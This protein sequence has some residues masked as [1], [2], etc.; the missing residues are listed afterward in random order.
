MA[1]LSKP[2]VYPTLGLLEIHDGDTFRLHIDVGFE[3]DAWPWLRLKGAFCPE[4]SAP[5]GKEARDFALN[6]LA[7]AGDQI[8]V[9]T[10]K[11]KGY[12]DMKKSFARY[13]AD[14]WLYGE[15]G[16]GTRLSEILI[17]AGHATATAT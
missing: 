2:R 9:V 16:I 4:L 7:D 3:H 11:L 15:P 8:W 14:V 6:K 1:D 17:T 5:G 10:Y 13:I 12:E